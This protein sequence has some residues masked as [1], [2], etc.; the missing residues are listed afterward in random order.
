ME[1]SIKPDDNVQAYLVLGY[2]EDLIKSFTGWLNKEKHYLVV[3]DT[4]SL[5][6]DQ[7]IDRQ[8]NLD[9][10][11]IDDINITSL[12]S[13]LAWR[14]IF[15]NI[16]L[17]VSESFKEKKLADLVSGKWQK[18]KTGVHLS[19]SAFADFQ[20]PDLA[21]V[22]K[23]IHEE[24]E[25]SYLA[26]LKGCLNKVPAIIC[27][28][29]PSLDQSFFKVEEKA[30]IFSGGSALNALNF[31]PHFIG[32][33]DSKTPPGFFKKTFDKSILFFSLK[34]PNEILKK[35]FKQKFLCFAEERYLFLRWVVEKIGV[36]F[37]PINTGWSTVTFLTALAVYFG[38]NPIIFNGVDLCFKSKQIYAENVAKISY[39]K[40]HSQAFISV[41]DEKGNIKKTQNDWL[42]SAFFLQKLT[43][44]N[45]S[46][47]FYN[48]S[49]EGLFLGKNVN[50]IKIEQLGSW[51]T[52]NTEEMLKPLE[53]RPTFALKKEL[54][55]QILDM[56]NIEEKTVENSLIELE[57]MFNGQ[58]KELNL[59][60]ISWCEE[61][62]LKVLWDIFK[63]VILRDEKQDENFSF[64]EKVN[65]VLFY[66]DVLAQHKSQLKKYSND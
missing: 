46:T 4:K 15:L 21:S 1:N 34:A 58:I 36:K 49:Q 24:I 41:K 8:P 55:T 13:K 59:K 39:K 29:G 18:I 28:A 56:I 3:L 43:D 57:K 6:R 30:L 63:L 33:T 35:T 26:D 23:N 50:P 52:I 19:A 11:E 17:I 10:E 5:L 60:E 32:L 7:K 37:D 51:D 38:C 64:K 65:K 31:A 66:K 62:V 53:L 40:K 44:D 20:L 54:N 2:S 48:T 61:N 45:P 16:E 14:F 25:C 27:G 22:M 9:V 42:M 12:L 47:T